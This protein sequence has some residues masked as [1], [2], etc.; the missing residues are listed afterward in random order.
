MGGE[1]K[2]AEEN[3]LIILPFPEPKASLDKIREQYPHVKITYR[4]QTYKPGQALDAGIEANG[5]IHHKWI[6]IC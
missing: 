3:L 1:S 2:Q 4:Q 5:K 6:Y